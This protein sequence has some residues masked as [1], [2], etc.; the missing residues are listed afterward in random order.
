M[1]QPLDLIDDY[2]EQ[3]L[4]IS[5]R[6][7]FE[8]HLQ[9]DASLRQSI[10]ERV[11]L[12]TQLRRL[13]L[14]GVIA[15]ALVDAPVAA[16]LFGKAV[17]AGIAVIVSLGI[18]YYIYS[19]TKVPETTP[20]SVPVQ[21][22][23]TPEKVTPVREEPRA[24]TAPKSTKNIAPSNEQVITIIDE[25]TLP[26]NNTIAFEEV[27]N[28]V[29]DAPLGYE[30][31]TKNQEE[32]RGS[33]D[34]ELTNQY[35]EAYRNLSKGAINKATSTFRNLASNA[36]FK[37]KRRAEWYLALCELKMNPSSKNAT[38]AKIATTDG[39]FFQQKAI[40]LIAI[41]EQKGK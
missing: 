41:L 27:D 33:E 10:D 16:P 9:A 23:P 15:E 40:R 36:A 34:S 19:S 25:K 6:L 32:V 35:Y 39:H 28:L 21:Q 37:N 17:I 38:L 22:S 12:K 14:K 20:Q 24:E 31:W 8:K 30:S 29:A 11:Q 5:D 3:N 1:F 18:S 13:K 2:L 7:E 26:Q 4:S